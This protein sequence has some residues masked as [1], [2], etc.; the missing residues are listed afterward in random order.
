[1]NK[2]WKSLQLSE[3]IWALAMASVC[4]AGAYKI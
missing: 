1:M 3:E 4:S 2:L